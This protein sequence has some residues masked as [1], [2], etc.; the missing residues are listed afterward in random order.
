MSNGSGVRALTDRHTDRYTDGTDS[1][2]ST[3]DARGKYVNAEYST[4][5]KTKIV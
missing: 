1:I 2:P 4:K 5:L 3:A